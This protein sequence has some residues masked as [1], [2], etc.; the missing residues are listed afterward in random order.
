[1]RKKSNQYTSGARRPER[2]PIIPV[3]NQEHELVDGYCDRH[4]LTYAQA[5][6][7]GL[8]ALGALKVESLHDVPEPYRDEVVLIRQGRSK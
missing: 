2:L 5:V 8:V 7:S 1:M 6:R 3:T 4:H